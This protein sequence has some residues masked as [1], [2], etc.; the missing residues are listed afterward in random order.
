M[1]HKK[2]PFQN[3]GVVGLGLIGGSL[4]LDL[5]ELGYK[6]YGLVH[7]QETASRARELGLATKIS[8]NEIILEN[9]DLVI[10]ALPLDELLNPKK[11]LLN[12]LPK[13]AVITDV[14]SVKAPI[15]KIWSNL[16]PRFIGC[17]PMA[18]TSQAGVEAGKKNLFKGRPWVS[19]PDSKTDLEAL[20]LV[21]KLVLSLGSKW[22]TADATNHDEAVAL[23]SHLP[24]LISAALIETVGEEKNNNVYELASKITSSGFADTTRIGGG[25]PKLGAT[26]ASTNSK[27]ILQGLSIYK[28]CLEKFEKTLIKED[29]FALEEKLRRTKKVRSKILSS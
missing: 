14:G 19:T 20:E 6:V 5:Q 10:L 2:Q 11:E 25:N 4:G 28:Q 8:T 16:H 12:A 7:R 27:A 21:R 18:G 24:V 9:C 29:W 13:K 1:N 15:L 26:M 17:H 22:I 3:I 23:I